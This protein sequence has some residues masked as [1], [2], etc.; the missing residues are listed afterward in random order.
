MNPM[1]IFACAVLFA[2]GAALIRKRTLN[3]LLKEIYTSAYVKKDKELFLLH[4][5][6]PQAKM[7]MSESSRQ[8]IKLHYYIANDDEEKVVKTCEKIR[9]M[10]LDKKN[11]KAFYSSAIGYYCEKG[12]NDS[13]VLLE[14]LKQKCDHDQDNALFLLYLDSQLL[15]DIHIKHDISK[16]EP[17]KEMIAVCE[18]DALQVIY[19]MRLAR[20]YD[21]ADRA[22]ESRQEL[23]AAYAIADEP[24]KRRIEHILQKGWSS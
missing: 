1:W 20:L 8:M 5:N 2:A 24:A 9:K 21:F 15:Y 13:L 19:R 22:K 11:A 4:V 10:R 23:Q 3:R 17:L 18:D 14:E 12:R 6:S 7:L 16:I